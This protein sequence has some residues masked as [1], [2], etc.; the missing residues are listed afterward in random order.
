MPYPNTTSRQCHASQLVA[1]CGVSPRLVDDI[2]M[3]M[4]PYPI[5]ISNTTNIRDNEGNIIVTSSGDYNDS[6]EITWDIVK[7]RCGAPSDMEFGEMTT[8]TKKM[9]RVFEMN[10]D[11]LKYVTKLNRPTMIALNF[12][13]YIDWGAYK[14]RKYSELPQKV[15]DFI[16]KVEDVTGVPVKLIGTGA[17]QYDIIDLR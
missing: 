2:I 16:N 14:C 5:R 12:A 13:Q 3:V 8:V 15:L 17:D 1:D 7:E 10:W 9:R 6:E 4:R 11:R